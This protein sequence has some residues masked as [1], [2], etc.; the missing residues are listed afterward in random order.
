MKKI[1]LIALLVGFS[2]G[3]MQGVVFQKNDITSKELKARLIEKYQGKINGIDRLSRSVTDFQGIVDANMLTQKIDSAVNQFIGMGSIDIDAVE[4]GIE[5]AISGALRAI[6]NQSIALANQTYLH[7]QSNNLFPIAPWN[8]KIVWN[9]DQTHVLMLTWIPTAYKGSYEGALKSGQEMKIVWDAWVTAVPE[10]KDF[11]KNYMK[12]NKNSFNATDRVE[13]FLGLLPSKP[14][15]VTSQNKLFVEMWVRPEDLFRPCLDAEI[16]DT[17][18]MIDPHESDLAHLPPAFRDMSKLIPM[19]PEHKAWFEKE[20]KGK[21]SGEWAMPWTRFGYTYD[22]GSLKKTQ[23]KR[24]AQG[25]TEY[26]IKIG[27]KVLIHSLIPTNVYGD[28]ITPTSGY[29]YKQ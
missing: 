28:S 15:Y 14:P 11:L 3:I 7:E 19:T 26:L 27:S 10:V 18:C 29:T 12:N 13:Q 1:S 4:E 5:K 8:N 24:A 21:Y 17:E 25:A 22:W 16:C 20:K 23:G 2:T 6:F 9:P